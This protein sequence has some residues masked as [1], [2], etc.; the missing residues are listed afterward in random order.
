MFNRVKELFDYKDGKLYWKS[1]S[2]PKSRI[3]IGDR[4]GSLNNVGYRRIGFDRKSH[5]EH[6][7][8]WLL[9]YG[10]LPKDL[11]HINRIRTDNRIENL[12][13]SNHS[14]NMMNANKQK[15]NYG[16]EC[17]SKY[18]GVSWD[19]KLKKWDARISLNRKI[20]FLGS[21]DSESEAAKAYNN[22]ATKLFGVFK[23]INKIGDNNE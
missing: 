19:K 7:L 5:L 8:V 6:R 4:A 3:E 9:H 11:D 15:T 12:R 10:N 21:F 2:S 22:K 23:N 17:T 13:E 16:R 20:I 18:K 14:Q 1:K